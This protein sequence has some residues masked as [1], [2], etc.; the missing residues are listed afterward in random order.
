MASCFHISK[1]EKMDIAKS[2]RNATGHPDDDD[3]DDNIE[4]IQEEENLP[5]ISQC[6]CEKATVAKSA[7][8]KQVECDISPFFY[9][10][11]D[12]HHVHIVVDSGQHCIVKLNIHTSL[13]QNGLFWQDTKS[14]VK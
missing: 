14:R 8:V 2:L 4:Y 9:A 6:I 11:Y 7:D 13:S 12:H 5:N 3:S 10:F 1:I